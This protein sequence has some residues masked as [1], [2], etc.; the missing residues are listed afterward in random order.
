VIPVPV[1][2]KVWQWILKRW[3][4]LP[5][6]ALA[7]TA[8][9]FR[10]QRDNARDD[11]AELTASLAAQDARYRAQVTYER[12]T[13]ADTVRGLEAENARLR[14]A[15]SGPVPVVRMCV[16]PAPAVLGLGA[17][18]GGAG[19]TGPAGGQLPGVPDGAA[20]DPF[21]YGPGLYAIADRADR[22][23]A[24]VRHLLDR[25]RKLSEMA[26]RGE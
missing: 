14:A 10:I 24:Q 20:A 3:W 16:G 11:V 25:H 1:L 17:P 7:V 6:A 5:I 18:A 26:S 8:T 13:T 19:G 12:Q 2:L 15:A 21:D 23:S 4:L 9:T 22:C